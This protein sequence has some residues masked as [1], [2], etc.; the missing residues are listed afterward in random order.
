MYGR[1]PLFFYP[2]HRI[3]RSRNDSLESAKFGERFGEGL[4][5]FSD[6]SASFLLVVDFPVEW[7]CEILWGSSL[8]LWS[9][10]CSVGKCPL[11]LRR[12]DWGRSVGQ[13][14]WILDEVLSLF[15]FSL[16]RLWCEEV[17]GGGDAA[18]DIGAGEWIAARESERR[19]VMGVGRRG[20]VA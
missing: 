16:K 9:A 2:R 13:V 3:S 4:K 15:A 6:G 17:R 20:G 18:G 7:L 11:V 14:C 12:E 5:R 8:Q 19:N 1:P 10:A